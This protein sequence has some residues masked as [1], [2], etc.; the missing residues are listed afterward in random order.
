MGTR[1]STER[2]FPQTEAVPY[3]DTIAHAVLLPAPHRVLQSRRACEPV[4]GIVVRALHKASSGP[5]GA[6]WPLANTRFACR[7]GGEG[8]DAGISGA[9]IVNR[10]AIV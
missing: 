8:A 7:E 5:C 2:A 10:P 1:Q 9:A 6:A 3:E 4:V